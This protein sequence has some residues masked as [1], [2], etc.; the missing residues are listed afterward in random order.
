MVKIRVLVNGAKGKM[1]SETVKAVAKE[2]DLELVGQTDLGDNLTKAI[3]ESKAEV[4][5]DFTQPNS[6]MKNVKTILESKA[7]AVIGTTGLS[8][9]NLAEIEKLCLKNEVNC[10]VAPNF[11]IGAVLMMKYAADAVKYLPQAEII[12]LHHDKKVDKPSGTAIKTAKLMGKEIPIHSVRLPGLVAHQEVIFGGLGQT[13]TIRHDTI[14]R[15]SF[16]PGVVMAVRKVK[17]AKG[18]VYGLENLL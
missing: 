13:L 1:G 14:N 9:A 7:H 2:N 8:D 5:I 15:E 12:E 18:L 17:K 10:V 16:M 4:V 6:A 3:A 11:A